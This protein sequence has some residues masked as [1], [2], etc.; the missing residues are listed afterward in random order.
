M[1][2]RFRKSIKIGPGTRLN[3]GSKSWGISAGRRGARISSNTRT[4]SRVTVGIPGTGL[5]YQQKIAGSSHDPNQ[6]GN[7]AALGGCLFGWA[8]LSPGSCAV[9]GL[10]FLVVGLFAL[11]VV[12]EALTHA[13]LIVA[14][15]L[16]GLAP[17]LLGIGVLASL[18]RF[19]SWTPQELQRAKRW[20]AGIAVGANLLLFVLFP[21]LI[22]TVAISRIMA[23]RAPKAQSATPTLTPPLNPPVKEADSAPVSKQLGPTQS[24]SKQVVPTRTVS[25]SNPLQDAQKQG[26]LEIV[27]S[28]FR[29]RPLQGQRLSSALLL[30]GQASAVPV[31]KRSEFRVVRWVFVLRN[32][33]RHPIAWVSYVPQ[34]LDAGGNPVDRDLGLD[35]EEWGNNAR[36]SIASLERLN[37]RLPSGQSRTVVLNELVTASAASRIRQTKI[38]VRG[39]FAR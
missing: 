1:G 13:V 30:D 34:F 33:S 5:S 9:G 31:E 7:G 10:I 32:S 12:V 25:K 4:G 15:L 18:V 27:R 8:L 21:R 16:T 17:L 35:Q 26:Q 38:S 19:A 2:W 36:P 29:I 6:G 39:H 24:V 37:L 11:S 14:A 20:V 23:P 22:P 28:A 3:L